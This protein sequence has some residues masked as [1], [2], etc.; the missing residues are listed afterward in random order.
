MFLTAV[1]TFL[2]LDLAHTPAEAPTVAAP[3]AVAQDAATESL[4]ATLPPRTSTDG[5]KMNTLPGSFSGTQVDGAFQVDE[6]GRLVLSQDIR[7]IFDYF[8]AAIGEEPVRASVERLQAYIAGQL[9]EPARGEALALLTH[10]L[11]YRRELVL[12][13]RDW[14]QLASLDALR[15][16]EAAVQALRARLFSRDAHQAFFAGEEA[17]NQFSLQRLAIQQDVNLDDAAKAA[18]VD[19]LRDGLPPELQ[20]SLLPQL[21]NELRAQTAKLQAA[22]ASPERVRQLRQQLVGAQATQRLEALDQKRLAWARRLGDYREAKA[23]IE[24]SRGLSAGD[25]AAAIERL[26]SEHF[27]E[28]ERLRLSAAEQLAEARSPASP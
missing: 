8:L 25:K 4:P 13:E 7:R 23:R 22:G 17:Y 19:R 21:Q 28:R 26:A 1:A 14:P 2:Y 18:A 9:Q 12:I 24:A 15:R 20:A 11:D 16:R 10:Y 5:S 6:A 27:D 3:P